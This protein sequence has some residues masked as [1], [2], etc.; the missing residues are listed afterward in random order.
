[1]KHVVRRYQSPG[2]D[3]ERFACMYG[4]SCHIVKRDEIWFRNIATGLMDGQMMSLE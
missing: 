2:G 1:M 3:I 4:V